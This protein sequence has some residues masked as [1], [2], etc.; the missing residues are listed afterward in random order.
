[1]KILV[2]VTKL[3]DGVWRG[4]LE[5]SAFGLLG[6]PPSARGAVSLVLLHTDP[7]TRG[8]ELV[9]E[10]EAASLL[11]RGAGGTTV[12]VAAPERPIFSPAGSASGPVASRPTTPSGG[13]ADF[14]RQLPPSLREVGTLLLNQVRERWPG[15][16]R[17][18]PA[19]RFVES[20]DNFWTV[21]I[22]PRDGSL[23]ITVRGAASK[24]P[25]MPALGLKDDRT[26]YSTFKIRTV[27]DVAAALSVL[28]RVRRS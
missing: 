13:D 8:G 28:Q 14:L 4:R 12:F 17:L 15:E 7:S 22:Q 21:K 6:R 27:A 1:M 5:P 25:S 19:G 20:P 26:G 18:T 16:L 2:D 11:N 24:F 10:T 3:G 9:V 23:R